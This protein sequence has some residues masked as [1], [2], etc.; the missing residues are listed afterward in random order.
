[1]SIPANPGDSLSRNRKILYILLLGALTALGPFTIDLYLPAFPALEASLGVSEAEVQLTLT[2]TTVGFALGQLVVG[3]LS[4]K[5]GR[6]LPLIL[7]T[8]LHITASLGA[9]LST[10]LATLGLFRV[11]MGIGAAGGGVVAMAMVRDLFTGYAMVRMF[12]RMALV[13]GL[14]PILA[15]VIGS[16]LLLVMPWP[17][18]FYFLAGYGTLVITAAI[19]L[20]RETLPR[21]LRGKSGLTAGQRYKLLFS[22]RIFVGLLLLGGMNF[23]GLFAYLS[24][25]P[26][27]FQ[28]VYGFSPQEYGLLFGINSLGI[29]AG[30]Q[31]SSRVIRRVPPQWI[32]ACST[33]WMFLMAVLIVIFDQL[34]LGLWGVMVPLWFYILGTGFTFPCVQVLALS[35][36]GAQ[37]GTAASLLGAATFMMA[38]I[39]SPVVGWFGDISATVMGGVQATSILLAAAA[40]WLVVR[41]RTV[42]SIH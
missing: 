24:A 6:R 33:A 4:D 18:I 29:V 14:A 5:F 42:P 38:G 30:V 19:L 9:A 31:T 12:S 1:M 22:D 34:G 32:L 3:P 27:L 21:E 11:V 41:P 25:S 13:N 15:P 10:D 20:V 35:K 16:Q 7:A 39:V 8:A 17:G 23:A 2:G 28:D 37:A 26:F 40:L 36:H